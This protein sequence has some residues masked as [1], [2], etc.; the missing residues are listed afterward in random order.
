MAI[1]LIWEPLQM[2]AIVWGGI[3]F[4][5]NGFP[6]IGLLWWLLSSSRLG[7][8]SSLRRGVPS[9]LPGS[10]I[11]FASS[12]STEIWWSIIVDKMVSQY[13]SIRKSSNVLRLAHSLTDPD[14]LLPR[15]WFLMDTDFEVLGSGPTSDWLVWHA[16]MDSAIAAAMLSQAETLTPTAEEH[17]A[18]NGRGHSATAPTTDA[19]N[20]LTIFD[21]GDRLAVALLREGHTL[22]QARDQI[23]CSK[24]GRCVSCTQDDRITVILRLCCS[25]A[26]ALVY[27]WK[28]RQKL[29]LPLRK[30]IC[31]TMCSPTVL[32]C[33]I[34]YDIWGNLLRKM[35]TW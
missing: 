26:A 13:W 33:L 25:V 10:S 4:W 16:D 22:G 32:F 2:Q 7:G 24:L 9:S 20:I 29:C 30:M 21:L 34:V 31:L 35:L 19:W 15:H 3:A 1:T 14:C 28:K 12:G 27:D 6:L 18:H 23:S 5:K 17:F 8:I 11:L